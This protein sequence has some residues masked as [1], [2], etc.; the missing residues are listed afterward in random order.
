MA[1]NSQGDRVEDAA[2]NF[3]NLR[4][5]LFHLKQPNL[6]YRSQELKIY[7]DILYA[8]PCVRIIFVMLSLYSNFSVRLIIFAPSRTDYLNTVIK[9]LLVHFFGFQSKIK[10][11][12]LQNLIL[13]FNRTML[14]GRK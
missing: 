11:F 12:Y 14:N 7:N 13:L 6:C 4:M 3:I 8:A 1:S 5:V 9:L 10:N 2:D